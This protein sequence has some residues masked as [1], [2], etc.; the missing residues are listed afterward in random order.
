ME[1]R[2][3]V[4]VGHYSLTTDG[5]PFP[6]RPGL[7]WLPQYRYGLYAYKALQEVCATA[8]TRNG[9]AIS[10]APPGKRGAGDV[11]LHLVRPVL[12]DCVLRREGWLGYVLGQAEE[13][14]ERFTTGEL[15]HPITPDMALIV[16]K[17]TG[18]ERL[19]N[20]IL[21][22]MTPASPTVE[23]TLALA[24]GYAGATPEEIDDAHLVRRAAANALTERLCGLYGIEDQNC[25]RIHSAAVG[26]LI[27]A[28]TR[29]MHFLKPGFRTCVLV[30]E[31]WDLLRCV[32]T[33]SP[34]G[35]RAVEGRE[36]DVFPEEAWLEA[37]SAKDI[38]FSYISYTNNPLGTT[39]SYEAMVKAIEAIRDDALFFID[40]TSLDTEE[41][42]GVEV[43][44][45]IVHKYPRKNLLIAKSFSKEYN[46]G[47]LRVGYGIFTRRDVADA[48]WPYMAAYSPSTISCEAMQALDDGNAHVLAA[49]RRIGRELESF[50]QAH[51]EIRLS[52]TTSNYTSLFFDDA[53]A[54]DG[55]AR[56]IEEAHGRKV[57]PG[58]LPMQGGGRMGLGKGEV[59]LMSMKRIPFLPTN[60]LRVLVTE[61]AVKQIHDVL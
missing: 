16:A 4:P 58:D 42:S 24:G 53:A 11:P 51:T 30:P 9:N 22:Y 17:Q 19:L 61:T 1:S 34:E 44:A 25:V 48:M 13:S 28:A 43:I 5:I 7:N 20:N 6:P 49:Y 12:M 31:Y 33:Y 14:L 21:L 32:L 59:S 36:R 8:L 52:S 45:N 60:A 26:G 55:A 39:V 57:F 18:S 10:F 27:E 3:D 47:H 23:A 38:D 54:C 41:S 29:Y 56:R 46:K 35:L 15:Y 37:I 50:A 40:C 2:S